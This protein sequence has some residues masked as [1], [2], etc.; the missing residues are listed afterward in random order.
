LVAERAFATL[1]LLVV[2]VEVTVH[3]ETILETFMLAETTERPITSVNRLRQVT[4]RAPQVREAM[5]GTTLDIVISL[6]PNHSTFE[7][8]E[9]GHTIEKSLPPETIMRS[10]VEADLVTCTICQA[11]RSARSVILTMISISPE[12]GEAKVLNRTGTVLQPH[13]TIVTTFVTAPI[14]GTPSP[15]STV[16]PAQPLWQV[17]RAFAIRETIAAIANCTRCRR[18]MIIVTVLDT[19]IPFQFVHPMRL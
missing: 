13:S 6:P 15:T 4:G 18:N 1:Q 2:E 10:S 17:P 8:P 9:M 3:S 5:Q 14:I 16:P 11:D 19:E 7:I 12:I